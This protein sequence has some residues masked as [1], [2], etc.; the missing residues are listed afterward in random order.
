VIFIRNLPENQEI[1]RKFEIPKSFLPRHI[2]VEAH[3]Y[4]YLGVSPVVAYQNISTM[5]QILGDLPAAVQSLKKALE[6]VDAP[7]LRSRLIQLE[8]AAGRPPS[9]GTR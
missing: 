9:R 1:I 6:T 3:H 7:F 8:Q 2:I 4:M 5:Y